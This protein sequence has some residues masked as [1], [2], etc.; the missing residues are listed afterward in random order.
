MAYI[1]GDNV[2]TSLGFSTAENIKKVS[3]NVC[4]ITRSNDKR[5][6]R[7]PV[8]VSLVDS[9][10]LEEEFGKIPSRK[11][12]TR[13]E[14][15]TILSIRDALVQSGVDG[16]DE[17]TGIIFSTTKGNIDLLDSVMAKRYEDH[18][19]HLWS[20]AK[21]IQK[22]IGNPNIPIIISNA[23]ISGSLAILVGQRL[24]NSGKFDHVI[25]AGADI[26]S[27][28][29]VSGFQSFQ[30]VSEEPCKPFDKNR[31]GITIGEG[32]GTI[33]L[34]AHPPTG[35]KNS[36]ITV[37]GGGTS[38]DANHISGP[39]RTGDGL[40]LAINMALA[41]AGLQAEEIDYISAHG[42]GTG[43]NDEMEAKAIAWASLE[44]KPVKSFKGCIG[45]TLGAAGIIESVYAIESLTR[46]LLFPS[47]G[48]EKLGVTKEL[49]VIE[50]LHK[51]SLQHCIK[52]A[53][54]FGGCNAAVIYR[55]ESPGEN[56]R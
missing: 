38:N 29:I 22:Y 40:Y 4:G 30:A 23:C 9:D 51:A 18:R 20:A 26:M 6:S 1:A 34:T 16:S 14:K 52:L 21:E 44:K 25:I 8:H 36:R 15:L 54:G 10:R 37:M 5:I 12:Y 13:L 53:S 27:E 35:K 2:I 45:H 50:N 31:N 32:A 28:F 47:M 39:S 56:T 3:E 11:E 7:V 17:R 48:F 55:K 33:V 42:T 49:N 41:D 43:Y 46:N 24:I 19:I